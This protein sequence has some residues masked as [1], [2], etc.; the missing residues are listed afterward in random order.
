MIAWLR[1]WIA[2]PLVKEQAAAYQRQVEEFERQLAASGEQAAR[3]QLEAY[4]AGQQSGYTGGR[5]QGQ[6]EG[7][8]SMRE[9]FERNLA[10]AGVDGD[11][12]IEDCASAIKR[13]PMVTH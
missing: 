3:A 11:A 4:Q 12:T 13:L 8:Q 2:S 6:Q 7:M 1:R 9:A 5:L 10:A